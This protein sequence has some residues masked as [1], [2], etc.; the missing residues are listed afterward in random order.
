ML[1]DYKQPARYPDFYTVNAHFDFWHLSR[2]GA[3]KF[4]RRFAGDFLALTNAGV[5]PLDR[6]QNWK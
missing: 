5:P 4:G 3:L 2:T 1:F 6:D